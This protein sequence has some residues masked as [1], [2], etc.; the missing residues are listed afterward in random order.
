MLV[1]NKSDLKD[2]RVISTD[3]GA[4]FAE[5]HLMGFIETS[6]L[7]GENVNNAFMTLINGKINS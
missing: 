7:S 1:G 6:A 5:T 3:V 4:A 2:Q